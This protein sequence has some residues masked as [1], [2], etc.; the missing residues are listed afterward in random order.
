MENAPHRPVTLA[1]IPINLIDPPSTNCRSVAG[2][3]DDLARSIRVHG[4]LTPLRLRP[5][6]GGRYEVVAGE[7]RWRAAQLAGLVE[8][9]AAIDA[10]LGEVELLSAQL[11]ENTDRL[12]LTQLERLQA[13]QQLLELGAGDEEVAAR[14]GMEPRELSVLRRMAALP[15]EARRLLDEGALAIA[16]AA[17]LAQIGDAE[18]VAQALADIADGHHPRAAIDRAPEK[19]R[20]RRVE[21][22]A[23]ARLEKQ[24]VR[25]IDAPAGYDFA[26]SST[27]RRLGPGSHALHV[28]V[29]KHRKEPCHAAYLNP[30]ARSSKDAIV[31][32]LWNRQVRVSVDTYQLTSDSAPGDPG[33]RE[34]PIS[35]PPRGTVPATTTRPGRIA[36]DARRA[37]A[38]A[39]PVGPLQG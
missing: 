9:P 29:K 28:D 15:D 21:C 3:V 7:R 27:T 35:R 2:E 4:L 10:E 26:A 38:G 18:V 19:V 36:E 23:R 5:V 32:V 33:R 39:R 17:M 22:A 12:E 24:R 8:V 11:A 30:W 16:D 14:T 6:D 34:R 13:V 20:R 37:D 1:H 31:H 25:I